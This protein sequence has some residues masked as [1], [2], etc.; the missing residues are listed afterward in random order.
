MVL[1]FCS[2]TIGHSWLL[3][4]GHLVLDKEATEE[5][6]ANAAVKLNVF[7]TMNFLLQQLGQE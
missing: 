5:E 4:T 7:H 3:E 2:E 1:C 6:I